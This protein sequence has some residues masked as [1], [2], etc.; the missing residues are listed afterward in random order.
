MNKKRIAR[1]LAVG[2]ITLLIV[3]MICLSQAGDPGE[4]LASQKRTRS[5]PLKIYAHQ[6]PHHPYTN[7]TYRYNYFL[8]PI[9]GMT[10]DPITDMGQLA[11]LIV[12]DFSQNQQGVVYVSTQVPPTLAETC[13]ADQCG[14]ALPSNDYYLRVDDLAATFDSFTAT[15]WDGD[16]RVYGRGLVSREDT[17]DEYLLCS[18]EMNTILYDFA[19]EDSAGWY[20]EV[21]DHWESDAVLCLQAIWQAGSCGPGGIPVYLSDWA[22]HEGKSIVDVV[23]E[24]TVKL[25][26]GHYFDVLLLRSLNDFGAHWLLDPQCT[27]SP[28]YEI[29]SYTYEW[30]A[31]YYGPVV[32]IDSDT[33]VPDP[34]SWTVAD[35]A[36]F[37]FG[38]FPPL[39][40]TLDSSA[41][42]SITISWQP[43]TPAELTDRYKVYWDTDSSSQVPYTYSWDSDS[44]AQ[45]VFNG[46]S[47]TITSL[48]CGTTY[49][50]TVT[51]L[52]AY[53]DPDSAITT[54][55]ES[56]LYPTQIHGS[57]DH[58]YPVEVEAST[59]ACSCAPSTEV[60][61]LRI[62]KLGDDLRFT[63]RQVTG[64]PCLDHYEV[65]GSDT[66][67]EWSG[68]VSLSDCGLET[69][70]VASPEEDYFLVVPMGPEDQLG[71]VGHYGM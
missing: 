58:L 11:G 26:S 49:Y 69:E 41:Q 19:H 18:E 65:F 16:N 50:V 27:H 15:D 39:T 3:E 21:G 44:S 2:A 70:W 64:D 59:T 55:Y 40:I 46:N 22:A 61:R 42:T 9:S 25:P 13:V 20:M 52:Y 56:L 34:G 10:P 51:A 35:S 71:R 57:P 66:A 63:W 8:I 54:E 45:V 28:S 68:F 24:G 23:G 43:G 36:T 47:A 17:A 53:T 67:H 62:G 38:L 4:D 1:D 37:A 14:F 5:L 33:N 30:F 12:W 32:T 29:H 48:Q 31:P 60:T 7:I 6:E